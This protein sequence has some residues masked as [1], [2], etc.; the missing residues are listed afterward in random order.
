MSSLTSS[1]HSILLPFYTSLRFGKPASLGLNSLCWRWISHLKLRT[2]SMWI[3]R[4]QTPMGK[5]RFQPQNIQKLWRLM[6][7]KKIIKVVSS[8]RFFSKKM[9]GR[10]RS[11][12][13]PSRSP[14]T[15]NGPRN[16]GSCDDL[17]AIR[18]KLHLTQAA[19]NRRSLT[20]GR[21]TSFKQTCFSN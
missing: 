21:L 20:E 6:T 18:T 14:E 13:I 15:G 16:T 2:V 8:H 11:S 3:L 12:H 17:I 9:S 4:P 19:K 7:P 10:K 1:T 5:F